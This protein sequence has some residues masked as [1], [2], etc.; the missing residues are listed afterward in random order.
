MTDRIAHAALEAIEG[1]GAFVETIV[2]PPDGTSPVVTVRAAAG[3]RMPPFESISPYA[4]SVTEQ[5]LES[6]APMLIPD[7]RQPGYSGAVGAFRESGGA[8]IVVPLGTLAAPVGALFVL[9]P[10]RGHFRVDDVARAAI[11]GHLAALAY[12][13]LRILDDAYDG[14]RKLER[15]LQ[16][17]SRLIR[18]FSHDVKNP[19]GAADGFAALLS[20]GI[21]GELSVDQSESIRRIRRCI[22]EALS[23]IDDL[24]ELAR[25]ETGHI[26]LPLEP[27][28]LASLV[29]TINEEYQAAA[30]A[31]GLSLLVVVDT[32]LPIVQTNGARVRQIV[33]NLLSNAIKYT[34]RGGV[35]IRTLFRA[36]GPFGTADHWALVEINDTG[37]GIPV[38]KQDFIFEE[39]SRIEGSEKPGAGLGLA[40]SRL[41]A[42][43]LGG[44]ISV[45]SELGEGSTFTLWLP[46]QESEDPRTTST[47]PT[48]I[49]GERE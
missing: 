33:S 24:H 41:L 27:V 35:T 4:G 3:A 8:A 15:V 9:S 47:Q 19:I 16:S 28:D 43:A 10:A 26:A 37:I 23:L 21:Y 5:V 25:A 20:E 44:H 49:E 45:V 32:G 34:E 29:C 31:G 13:K 12:E 40:I 48:T 1:Q 38:N 39:F 42:E 2:A 22:R 7:L 18:G 11:F 6:G 14:R 30:R 46:V 36:E 17:R